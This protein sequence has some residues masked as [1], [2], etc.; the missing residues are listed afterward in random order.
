MDGPPDRP[1]VVLSNSL[2][3]TWDL[4]DGVYPRLVEGFRV[5][6]YDPRGHGES[7]RPAGEYSIEQLGGDLLAVLDR[8][9][10]DRA[11]CC[12]I[13]LGGLVGQWLARR[14]PERLDRLVLANTGAKIGEADFWNRRIATVLAEGMGPIVEVLLARWF[15]AGFRASHPATVARFGAML[16]RCDPTGYAGCCAAVRDADFRASLGEIRAPTLVIAGSEDQATSPELAAALAAGIGG[17]RLATLPTAH[18][19]NVEQPEAFAALVV[20]FLS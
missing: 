9:G 8:A 5:V 3:S 18:L 11:H 20:E 4:W 13:S 10:V 14:A 12:G 15:T 1:A 16:A 17:A 19:S 6:R 2:G 7:A